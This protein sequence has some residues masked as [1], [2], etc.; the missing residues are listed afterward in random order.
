M[1][2]D[3][4]IEKPELYKVKNGVPALAQWVNDLAYPC[5]GAGSLRSPAQWV[6]DSVLPQLWCRLQLC[7]GGDYKR[8]KKKKKLSEISN[9]LDS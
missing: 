3:L 7:Q 2:Y 1:L 8:E 9:Y 6:K 4:V 5:G